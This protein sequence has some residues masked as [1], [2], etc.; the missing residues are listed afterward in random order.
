MTGQGISRQSRASKLGLVVAVA[1]LIAAP[2]CYAV[3]L[4][5]SVFALNFRFRERAS[6]RASER[7]SVRERAR[8]RERERE[9]ESESERVCE[10]D[11]ECVL[12]RERT[13]D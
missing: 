5:D 12:E 8:E 7:E 10:R 11:R 1:L 2:L 9:T 4:Q 6:E 13:S 3:A